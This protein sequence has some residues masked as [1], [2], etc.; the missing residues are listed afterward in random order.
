MNFLSCSDIK[1]KYF[2]CENNNTEGQKN[3][4]EKKY[5]EILYARKVKL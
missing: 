2:L 1:F 4:K 3:N 5:R